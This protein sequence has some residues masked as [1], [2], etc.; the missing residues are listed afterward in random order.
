MTTWA[1]P[2]TSGAQQIAYAST[3]GGTIFVPSIHFNVIYRYNAGVSV[4][5]GSSGTADGQFTT[6]YGVATDLSGNLYV[7]DSGNN[8]IQMFNS[9]GAWQWSSPSSGVTAGSANGLFNFPTGLAVDASGDVWVAD[10]G[11]NR[12]VKLDPTGAYV[13]SISGTFG[14]L[15]ITSPWAVATD[16]IHNWV[17]VSNLF[18][19]IYRFQTDGTFLN[20]L[21]TYGSSG[22]GHFQSPDALAVDPTGN[23]LYVV[24]P[25]Q[26]RVQVLSPMGDFGETF[27]NYS[28]FG[29][30]SPLGVAV[31]GSGNVYVASNGTGSIQVYG[32]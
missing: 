23:R 7:A 13:S 31:D 29:S 17:Y 26:S 18:C 19:C 20:Q 32:P 8:R 2:V 5:W 16:N 6:P 12:L 11:N 28:I 1:L 4:V 10:S 3:S 21:G 24:D 15:A 27:G 30:G 25:N 9:S 14:G 22:N